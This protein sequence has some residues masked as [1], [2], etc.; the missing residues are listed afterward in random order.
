MQQNKQPGL[1]TP[2]FTV[3]VKRYDKKTLNGFWYKSK[4]KHFYTFAE[5]F[6]FFMRFCTFHKIDLKTVNLGENVAS[7]HTLPYL[8]DDYTE[9][10]I[11]KY[12]DNEI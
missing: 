8:S 5:A 12:T 1:F 4:E 6:K 3:F 11:L 9:V 2:Y 7:A 10:Y